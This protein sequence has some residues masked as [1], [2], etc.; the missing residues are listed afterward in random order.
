MP[1][2]VAVAEPAWRPAVKLA[3]AVVTLLPRGPLLAVTVAV[4]V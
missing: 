1:M 3:V 4:A 2:P